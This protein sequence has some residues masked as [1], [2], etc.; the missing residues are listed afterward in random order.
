MFRKRPSTSTRY[1]VHSR[2]DQM[3]GQRRL[4]GDLGRF[5][6]TNFATMILS[7]VPQNRPQAAAKVSPFF[8]LTGI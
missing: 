3:P 8:S 4:D 6:V 2:K 7:V 1:C 5:V